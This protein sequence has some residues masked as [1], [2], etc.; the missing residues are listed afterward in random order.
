MSCVHLTSCSSHGSP[1]CCEQLLFAST[2]HRDPLLDDNT[3]GR[4]IVPPSES[5]FQRA[6]RRS[7]RDLWKL[8]KTAGA[9]SP[10]PPSYLVLRKR[11]IW[12]FIHYFHLVSWKQTA[13]MM[14]SVII[15][16]SSCSVNVQYAVKSAVIQMNV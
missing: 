9:T 13:V 8:E 11:E 15:I 10:S 2:R 5:V 12:N 4:Q 14:F 6:G 16:L 3:R 1:G 7:P